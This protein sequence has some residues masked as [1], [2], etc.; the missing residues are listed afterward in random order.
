MYKS[1]DSKTPEQV[2]RSDLTESK[3]S[4]RKKRSKSAIDIFTN[5]LNSVYLESEYRT[6]GYA[7]LFIT[8]S[9]V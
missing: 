8:I 3:S 4:L 6:L 7:Q 2:S 9:L 1:T 5:N